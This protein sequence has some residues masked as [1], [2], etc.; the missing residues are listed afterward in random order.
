MFHDN[1]KLLH[2]T[3]AP[4]LQLA[5][6]FRP[7]IS[8]EGSATAP[9]PYIS[10]EGSTTASRPCISHEGSV[11]VPRPCIKFADCNWSHVSVTVFAQ[12][13]CSGSPLFSFQTVVSGSPLFSFSGSPLFSFH[14]GTVPCRARELR[15]RLDGFL[16][17]VAVSFLEQHA[18]VADTRS[19]DT[20]VEG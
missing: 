17:V 19:S 3:K 12:A 10:Y 6:A 8:H 1:I 5:S 7:C 4:W 14:H 20:T 9:S 18:F 11:T 2:R 16:F 15:R 13:I